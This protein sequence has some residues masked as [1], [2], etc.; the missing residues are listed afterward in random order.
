MSNR[1]FLEM[2]EEYGE[3]NAA[4]TMISVQRSHHTKFYVDNPGE[5][6]GKS[7]NIPAGTVVESGPT[8]SIFYDFYLCSHAGIQGSG[9]IRYYRRFNR[10]RNVKSSALYGDARRKQSFCSI[11]AG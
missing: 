3:Y 2:P 9:V 6:E 4:V 7:K 11:S 1:D 10:S 5:G 8:S